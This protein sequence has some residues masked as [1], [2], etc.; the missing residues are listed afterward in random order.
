LDEN[1]RHFSQKPL[2]KNGNSL[3]NIRSKKS[4]EEME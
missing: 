1:G 2:E 4:K 3:Y